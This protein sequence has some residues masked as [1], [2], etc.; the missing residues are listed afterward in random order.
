MCDS[1]RPWGGA[2]G[3]AGAEA[4]CLVRPRGP[5]SLL[6]P[7]HL[8]LRWAPPPP[9]ISPWSS[10]W[11]LLSE[12]LSVPYNVKCPPERPLFLAFILF[13]NSPTLQ[14]VLTALHLKLPL[15]G[16]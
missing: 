12:H 7:R 15:S 2:R 3:L 4:A 1:G 5:Q 9:R 13:P 11:P 10:E 6:A 14:A 8:P 16:Q